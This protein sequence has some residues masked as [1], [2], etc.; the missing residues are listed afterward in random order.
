[1]SDVVSWLRGLLAFQRS[2]RVRFAA[3]QQLA[4]KKQENTVKS[5]HIVYVLN[6]VGM[7]GGTKIILEHATQ[8]TK[9]GAKVTLISHFSRPDWYPFAANFI[10]IPFQIELTRGLPDCDV[11][12]ATYWEHIQAC[13]E[14]GIAPVVYFEQGDFHLYD[15]EGDCVSEKAKNVVR[16]QYTLAP[17]ITT[18]SA[19]TAKHIKGKF[20]RESTVFHNALDA[21]VFYPKDNQ[22]QSD[23]KYM[24][25]VGSEQTSFKGIEDLHKVYNLLKQKGYNIELLWLTQEP[26]IHSQGDVFVN[27]PLNLIGDLY[28]QAYVY[29]CG[30]YYESFPLPPLEAMA[31]GTPVVTTSNAGVQE[32][33]QDGYNCLMTDPGDIE[34]L[35]NKIIQLLNDQELYYRLQHNGY[36]TANH[37][38]WNKIAKSLLAYYQ[39]VAQYVPLPQST[40][41]DWELYYQDEDFVDGGAALFI[42]KFLMQTAADLILFPIQ[43]NF[44][45]GRELI[46]WQVMARRKNPRHSYTDKVYFK[47]KGEKFSQWDSS[48]IAELFQKGQFDEALLQARNKIEGLPNRALEWAVFARWQIMCL[49]EK[50]QY[51]DAEQLLNTAVAMHPLY[52]DLYFVRAMIQYSKG[53]INQANTLMQTCMAIQDAMTYPEHFANICQMAYEYL[54][55]G[56]EHD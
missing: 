2:K 13:V 3:P 38:Q 50:K 21:N 24:M 29:V 5:I 14:T 35:A 17:Y 40:V 4:P 26:P 16:M 36:Q 22:K 15:W 45:P 37:F 11:I 32:Y 8:L 43:H 31:C 44:L 56:N 46:T 12:V 34:G 25:I 33:A 9:L 6:H 41:E 30:S 1:M 51:D 10:T 20:G 19:T 27:P 55:R 42:K 18:V 49:Y 53:N 52:T 23:K 48:L 54:E 7:C 47:L 28:R 39:E